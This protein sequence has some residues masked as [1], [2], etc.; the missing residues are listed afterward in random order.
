M[1]RNTARV[2]ITAV[3]LILGGCQNY[4]SQTVV[5]ASSIPDQTYDVTVYKK[6]MSTAYAVVLDIPDDGVEVFMRGTPFTEKIGKDSPHAYIHEFQ[7][8]SWFYKTISIGDQDGTVKGY[9]LVSGVLRY[10]ISPSGGRIMVGIEMEP[11][12]R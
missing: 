8:R 5:D 11:G 12:Y 2:T 3:V 9:L 7:E 4:L 6:F 10:W 1:N